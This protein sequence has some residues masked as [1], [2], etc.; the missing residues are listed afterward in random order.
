MSPASRRPETL[1]RFFH[2][3]EHLA[4]AMTARRSATLAFAV[5][6]AAALIMFARPLLN[7]SGRMLGI[8]TDPQIFIW[9]L[10]W[11]PHAL[12]H[13]S[14]PLVS[15]AIYYPQGLDLAHGALIPAAAL[16]LAPVTALLG[17][18]GAYNVAMVLSPVLAAWFC[19]LLCVRLTRSGWASLV[20]GWLFGFSPYLL[21][22]MAGHLHLTLVFAVPAIVLL[23]V[24]SVDGR[25]SRGVAIGAI[26]L[27]L[28]VQFYIAAEVFVSLSLFGAVALGWAW[29]WGDAEERRRL[30]ELVVVLTG[31]YAVTAVACAPYL[32]EAF[33]PGQVPVLPDRS[34]AISADLL[35]YVLPSQLTAIGGGTFAA[36]TARFT[37]G[38]IEGGAYIALPLLALAV[39]AVRSR[40][41]AWGMRVALG[42]LSVIVV[43]S[44]GGHLHVGGDV[45]VVLPWR[46]AE[47]LPVLG[48]L[49]PARFSMFAYL[50]VG[51]LAAT[52]LARTRARW[53]ALALA[54]IA[55]VAMW[56]AFPG[57]W[58]SPAGLP[59]LLTTTAYERSVGPRDVA[60]VLPIGPSGPSMLWQAMTNFR[61]P[62]A[63]GYALPPEAR[64]PYTD[65]PLYPDLNSVP[66]ANAG[67]AARSFLRRH[68]VSVVL[69][70]VGLPTTPPWQAFLERLGWH[71]VQRGGVVIMRHG[72]LLGGP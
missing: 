36:T 69:M 45:S 49:L 8:G 51:I 17:P 32:Y 59:E 34:D 7:S 13:A 50:I 11:W 47:H 64:N 2:P 71:G 24:L 27:A 48:L 44:L 9:A 22:Q 12:L 61:F 25:L 20:A 65:D 31:A 26:G 43:F 66:A 6:L 19:Y 67:P 38:P 60:L 18:L 46:A 42:T 53:V 28:T 35:S 33:K 15:H 68:Q 52:W 54:A 23:A 56:P 29:V 3:I 72:D 57:P 63:A 1:Q 40:W 14:N 21:G 39:L 4:P 30:R 16:I 58:N 5:Y 10:A 37:E 70:P 41:R 55:V 62:I